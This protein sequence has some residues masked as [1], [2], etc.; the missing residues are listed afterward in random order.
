MTA[1]FQTQTTHFY[2]ST[3][4][5]TKQTHHQQYYQPLLT[6][7]KHESVYSITICDGGRI[8]SVWNDAYQCSFHNT[9]KNKSCGQWQS[10]ITIKFHII[11]TIPC[12]HHAWPDIVHSRT[13]CC[14]QEPRAHR[15]HASLPSRTDKI[16]SVHNLFHILN[17]TDRQACSPIWRIQSCHSYYCCYYSTDYNHI[18]T[19]EISLLEECE[20]LQNKAY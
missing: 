3:H 8:I 13:D 17:A 19:N 10:L 1:C 11:C 18:N 7:L 6:Q 14:H 12:V 5:Y 15:M 2:A 4:T 9:P 20:D 16:Q